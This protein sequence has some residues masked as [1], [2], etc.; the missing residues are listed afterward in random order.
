MK[1]GCI[2]AVLGALALVIL[3]VGTIM[4]TPLLE[5]QTFSVIYTYTGSGNSA[6]A[7]GGLTIDRNRNLRALRHGVDRV[8]CA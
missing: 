6:H 8:E 3:L 2:S 7:I 1:R 4:A 5:A